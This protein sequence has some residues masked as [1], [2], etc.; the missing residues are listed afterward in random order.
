MPEVEKKVNTNGVVISKRKCVG[1][2]VVVRDSK[3]EVIAALCKRIAG[4][5]GALET[6]A[7]AMEAAVQFAVD[8]GLREVVF[9]GDSMSIC[10]MIQGSNEAKSSIQ[11]VVDG[12]KAQLLSFRVAEVSYVKRQGNIPAHLLAQHA[13]HVEDY[14][15]WLEECSSP[16][17]H[18]CTQDVL[19]LVN[20]E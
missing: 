11:S 3:G 9:E 12:I 2:G 17:T 8:I 7:L 4:L 13:V 6:E 16:I 1:I 19:H 20:S 10:K 18:A 15:A 5:M 14:V